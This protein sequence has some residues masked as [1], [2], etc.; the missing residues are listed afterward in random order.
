MTP[1]TKTAPVK[2]ASV[3][4]VWPAELPPITNEEA[5]ELV[6][7]LHRK[8][9][10]GRVPAVKLATG[11]R[12][13]WRRNGIFYVNP[14]RRKNGNIDQG[15]KDIVHLVSHFVHWKKY[16]TH[17]PHH[18][19]HAWTE[20]C[21]IEHVVKSGWLE[22]KLKRKPKPVKP[23]PTAAD[24]AAAKLANLDARI[25]RWESKRRRAETALQKLARQY[26]RLQRQ[27]A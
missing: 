3:N 16:P 19:T 21:M 9:M 27:A 12:L 26:R 17:K 13:T 14:N 2:Y 1:E 6:R 25:K 22:G 11:N 8:F 7:R 18:P 5:L 20:R 23:E 15:W 4:G 24:R 10:D